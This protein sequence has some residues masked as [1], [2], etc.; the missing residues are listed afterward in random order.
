LK[1]VE[2]GIQYEDWP[3]DGCIPI[4]HQGCTKWTVLVLEGA[5]RGTV[6]DMACFAGFDGEWVSAR[7]PDGII[8]AP[9]STQAELP[10]LSNPPDFLEWIESWVERCKLDLSIRS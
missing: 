4:G 1:V 7:R 5:L 2:A 6:W 10:P 3:N 9:D 8:E